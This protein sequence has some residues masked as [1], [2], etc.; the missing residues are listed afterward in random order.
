MDFKTISVIVIIILIIIVILYKNTQDDHFRPLG[1]SGPD[2]PGGPEGLGRPIQI[3]I[4]SY[5]KMPT[6][7]FQ[8]NQ[9][10][11]PFYNWPQYIGKYPY[12][13]FMFHPYNSSV[14]YT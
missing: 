13:K 7:P 5:L 12:Y 14:Y 2:G 9:V 8:I 1:P 3:P 10:Y 6:D 11:Y 4:N